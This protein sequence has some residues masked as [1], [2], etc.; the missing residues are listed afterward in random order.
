[1]RF[2]VLEFAAHAR[3][4]SET[5]K[6]RPEN[7][8]GSDA[9][10]GLRRQREGDASGRNDRVDCN[11][12]GAST[13]SMPPFLVLNTPLKLV[14]PYNISV[15]HR[16]IASYSTSVPGVGKYHLLLSPYRACDSERVGR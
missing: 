14:A 9:A 13:R 4:T 8:D 5:H 7:L 11:V 16:P 15:P 2:L 1:M 3:R 6:K 12:A 10:V